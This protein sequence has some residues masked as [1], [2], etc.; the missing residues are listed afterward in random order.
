M[1]FNFGFKGLNGRIL[2]RRRR[3]YQSCS[4]VEEEGVGGVGGAEGGGRGGEGGGG[5]GGGG[6]G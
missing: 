5:G 3:L 1:G 4:A 2:S 6:G